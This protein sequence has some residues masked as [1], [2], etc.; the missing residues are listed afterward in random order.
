MMDDEMGDGSGAVYSVQR[1]VHVND[2]A[3]TF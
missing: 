2:Y 1:D 3:R